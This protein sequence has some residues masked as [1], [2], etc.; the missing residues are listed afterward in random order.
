MLGE[1]AG[2]DRLFVQ[3]LLDEVHR[4]SQWLCGECFHQILKGQDPVIFAM[5]Q[6]E[7]KFLLITVF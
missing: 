1:S 6:V 5:L 2:A 7:D 4:G 3:E